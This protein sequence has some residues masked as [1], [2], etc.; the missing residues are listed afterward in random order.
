MSE[1][2]KKRPTRVNIK[3]SK[4]PVLKFQFGSIRYAFSEVPKPKIESILKMVKSLEK[5]SVD[6]DSE[7]I[8]WRDSTSF[9]E[10]L[11]RV[12]GKK[13][14]QESALMLKGARAKENMTQVELANILGTKQ[15]NISMIENGKR[16]IGKKLAKRLAEIFNVNYKVFL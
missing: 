12:G 10:D 4:A 14:H 9:K 5:Y 1:P 13:E 2:M 15:H 11:K 6:D 8:N 7:S 16:P 3:K